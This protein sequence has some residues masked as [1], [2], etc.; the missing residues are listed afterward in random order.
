MARRQQS[1]VFPLHS[2]LFSSSRGSQPGDKA[3]LSRASCYALLLCSGC[4]C[5]DTQKEGGAGK[6]HAIESNGIKYYA[7]YYS[8]Q[9]RRRTNLRAH[10]KIQKK[11]FTTVKI[12]WSNNKYNGENALKS[13]VMSTEGGCV[14]LHAVWQASYFRIKLLSDDKIHLWNNDDV[15]A[16]AAAQLGYKA[17]EKL[18]WVEKAVEDEGVKGVSWRSI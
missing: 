1:K 14:V 15:E 17:R 12:T 7:H 5:Q 18:A 6:S 3:L 2:S 10:L 13:S 4:S 8:D 16:L 9:S 11:H